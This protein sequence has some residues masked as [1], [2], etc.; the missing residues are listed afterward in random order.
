MGWL[1]EDARAILC[2][3]LVR[4]S[5]LGLSVTCGRRGGTRDDHDLCGQVSLVCIAP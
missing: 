2:R 4:K 3:T 5:F 1:R